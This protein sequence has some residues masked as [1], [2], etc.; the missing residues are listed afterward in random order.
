MPTKKGGK[1]DIREQ[2]IEQQLTKEKKLSI[3][4][5][6]GVGGLGI[7]IVFFWGYSLW[8]NVSTF[9]WSK[10]EENKIL[11]QTGADWNQAFQSVRENELQKELTKLQIKE[12]INKTL[13][14]QIENI[15]V[16]STTSTID[17]ATSTTSTIVSTTTNKTTTTKR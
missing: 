5:W 1:I 8:S 12:L 3:W 17:I 14:E 10:T 7:L 4:L 11:K 15:S 16:T 2:F 6:I 13:K 9:N